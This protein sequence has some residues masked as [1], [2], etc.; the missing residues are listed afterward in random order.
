MATTEQVRQ[1]YGRNKERDLIKGLLTADNVLRPG[2]C[3]PIS[4]ELYDSGG[5]N[6]STTKASDYQARTTERVSPQQAKQVTLKSNISF[7][8]HTGEKVS[9]KK[10]DFKEKQFSKVTNFKPT[11]RINIIDLDPRYETDKPSIA[12]S[13]SVEFNSSALV[14]GIKVGP[15]FTGTLGERVLPAESGCPKAHQEANKVTIYGVGN[16]ITNYLRATHF[17]LGSDPA[18]LQT[19]AQAA[20]SDS[21]QGGE[22]NSVAADR[23]REDKRT[24]NVFREGDYNMTERAE[25]VSVFKMSYSSGGAASTAGVT[26]TQKGYDH[27]SHSYT[28]TLAP[29]YIHH[30]LNPTFQPPSHPFL[31][32]SSPLPWRHSHL[33]RSPHMCVGITP[34]VTNPLPISLPISPNLPISL[35]SLSPSLIYSYSHPLLQSWLMRVDSKEVDEVK[36]TVARKLYN[37][38]RTEFQNPRDPNTVNFRQAFAL[39]D[40]KRTGFVSY[41]ALSS[42]LRRILGPAEQ[43]VVVFIFNLKVAVYIVVN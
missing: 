33:V 9:V 8:S 20:F 41:E 43:E 39:F 40:K 21:K 3:R 30:H 12:S 19:E 25:P 6:W 28:T 29:D 15:L 2:L 23:A 37:F 13:H 11:N 14:S 27:V 4:S 10:S 1:L 7:G 31:Y 16:P 17:S 38:L 18:V 32:N 26:S 24:N 34:G 35:L 42:V 22:S 5:D 36:M